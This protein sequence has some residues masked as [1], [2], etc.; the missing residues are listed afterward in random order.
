MNIFKPDIYSLSELIKDWKEEYPKLKITQNFIFNLANNCKLTLHAEEIKFP[1]KIW[2]TV[3]KYEYIVIDGKQYDDFNNSHPN[4][5]LVEKGFLVFN[6]HK[7]SHFFITDNNNGNTESTE[8]VTKYLDEFNIENATIE[9]KTTSI[10]TRDKNTKHIEELELNEIFCNEI[11]F[12]FYDFNERTLS[13]D[14]YSPK[15]TTKNKEFGVFSIL[16]ELKQVQLKTVSK[17]K[18]K[19]IYILR[20]DKKQT[21]DYIYEEFKKESK[22]LLGKDDKERIKTLVSFVENKKA[23]LQ[24][25]DHNLYFETIKGKTILP[26]TGKELL[27]ELF[28]IDHTRFK[29]LMDSKDKS[30]THKTFWK[31]QKEYGLVIPSSELQN[32]QN[33]LL[34]ET[35][36][37]K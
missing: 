6:D 23:I 22:I 28:K 27:D 8:V 21:E 4:L 11:E 32:D 7:I 9:C 16:E 31:E 33:K 25:K 2:S 18:P 34:R 30:V 3:S 5:Y 12:V 36:L 13:S 14:N 10:K 26:Y 37:T 1:Y 35:L 17:I 24:E 19:N 29:K 15:V 20:E